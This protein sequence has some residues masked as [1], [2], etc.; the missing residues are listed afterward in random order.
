MS[1]PIWGPNPISKT[2]SGPQSTRGGEQCA[3]VRV[4]VRHRL[5]KANLRSPTLTDGKER[6]EFWETA[7][8]PIEHLPRE[9]VDDWRG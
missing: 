3:P 2:R 8:T 9:I 5:M 7:S 1:Q 6:S 4:N